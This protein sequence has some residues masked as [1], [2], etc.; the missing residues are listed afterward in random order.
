M[1]DYH[2]RPDMIPMMRFMVENDMDIGSAALVHA[3]FPDTQRGDYGFRERVSW[4]ELK[5]N[6][7]WITT[8]KELKIWAWIRDDNPLGSG[9]WF[10]A[11]L[12]NFE[13]GEVHG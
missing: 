6:L 5:I 2:F 10:S 13:T 3:L 9:N 12:C 1:T 8:R 4:A 11:S 7:S